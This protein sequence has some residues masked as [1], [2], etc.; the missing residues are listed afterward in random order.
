VEKSAKRGAS[1]FLL[2]DKYNQN[3]EME[4]NEMGG[5]CSMNGVEEELIG[6]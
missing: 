5:A 4:E 1:W 3:D 2:F 6:Y